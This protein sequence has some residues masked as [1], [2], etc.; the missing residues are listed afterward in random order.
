MDTSKNIET[1]QLNTANSLIS[2]ATEKQEVLDGFVYTF[3]GDEQTLGKLFNFISYHRTALPLF[4]FE[5]S[6]QDLKSSIRLKITGPDGTKEV[7]QQLEF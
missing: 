3:K 4:R 5:L 6:I 2:A 1:H 7:L